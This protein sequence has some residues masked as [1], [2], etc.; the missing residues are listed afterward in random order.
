M[1]GSNIMKSASLSAARDDV[2]LHKGFI[3]ITDIVYVVN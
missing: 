2:C 1:K 3:Y